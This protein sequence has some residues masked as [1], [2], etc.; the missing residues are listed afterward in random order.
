MYSV[1]Y[2]RNR[3]DSSVFLSKDREKVL[4]AL[5]WYARFH[6]QLDDRYVRHALMQIVDHEDWEIREAVIAC[7]RSRPGDP[8]FTGTLL[9]RLHQ[10]T[11]H[12]LLESLVEASIMPMRMKFPG[13]ENVRRRI[14]EIMAGKCVGGALKRECENALYW[15][16]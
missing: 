15:V 5:A 3:P 11:D 16:Q 4:T 9:A 1:T 2:Y 6:S 12:E 13:H 14:R 7:L 8:E 10:E